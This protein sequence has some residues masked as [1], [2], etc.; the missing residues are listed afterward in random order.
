[1]SRPISLALALPLAIATTACTDS[2][3]SESVP[4]TIVAKTAPAETEQATA[5][6]ASN[7]A[8]AELAELVRTIQPQKA[9]N[10]GLRFSDAKLVQASAA[11]LL[12]ERLQSGNESEEVRRALVLALPGTQGKYAA[13]AVQLLRTERSE[14]LRA[15]LVGSMRLANDSAAALEGLAL[16]MEDSATS[17]RVRAA[18]AI[19]RRADGL[20]LADSLVAALAD[21]ST[22]LQATATRALGNLAAAD[23]FDKVAALLASGDAQVRLEALRALGRIDAARAAKRPELTKLSQDSDERIRTAATK[24]AAKS[25]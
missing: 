15:A 3:P 14:V 19:G 1:M 20:A 10:G 22:E 17:V 6:Q 18:F 21:K 13:D 11:P 24:V 7:V 5:P 25:Y 2:S 4:E 23:A 12:L 8:S 16:G 9:R